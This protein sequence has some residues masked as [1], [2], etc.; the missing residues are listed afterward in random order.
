MTVNLDKFFELASLTESEIAI[1]M[2][3]ALSRDYWKQ[4]CP[5]LS[6]TELIS[7]T[8]EKAITD[9]HLRELEQQ[10]SEEGYFRC[11]GLLNSEWMLRLANCIELLRKKDW[12]GVFAFVYDDF[13]LLTMGS[14]ISRLLTTI[15]GSGYRR[16]SHIWAYFVPAIDGARGWP[17]H[18]DGDQGQKRVTIW[19]PITDATL[20]NGCMFLIPQNL[21]SKEHVARFRSSNPGDFEDTTCLLQSS[22][23]LPSAAGSVLCW[24][25]GIIHWGSISRKASNPR[26]SVG[27]S[28]IGPNTKETKAEPP[29]FDGI[30]GLPSFEDR[31]RLV[32]KAILTYQFR[33]PLTFRY[34]ELA[35]Q[36]QNLP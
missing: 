27:F 36:L 1:R 4:L 14:A 9:E 24:D 16:T 22:R 19:I 17:P 7:A 8:Q 13:W 2:K 32:G 26:I 28:F 3:R 15:L 30:T 5:D 21:I 35:K 23:A 33:E 6:L 29:L 10:F 20:D 31:L 12:P 11:E 25:Y 18:V 34:L